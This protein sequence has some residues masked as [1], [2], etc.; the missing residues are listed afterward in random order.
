M[1]LALSVF[2][3]RKLLPLPLISRD[4]LKMV[5]ADAVMGLVLLVAPAAYT[6]QGLLMA[7]TLGITVYGGALFLFNPMALRSTVQQVLRRYL[8]LWQTR[9]AKL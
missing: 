3:G 4:I 6:W 8:W 9:I 5:A 1:G 7:I 2:A